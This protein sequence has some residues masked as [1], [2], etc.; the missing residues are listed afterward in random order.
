MDVELG[1]DR[2]DLALVV[3]PCPQG[4]RQAGARSRRLGRQRLQPP[5]G[6][7]AESG[8][9]RV[10]DQG[11]EVVVGQRERPPLHDPGVDQPARLAGAVG[12]LP[13]GQQ[14]DR[15]AEHR[16]RR[17]GRALQRRAQPRRLWV[18]EQRQPARVAAK[19]G[20]QRARGQPG[21]QP[22]TVA[23]P[24]EGRDLRRR[25]PVGVGGRG[26]N[27]GLVGLGVEQQGREPPPQ[28]LALARGGRLRLRVAVGRER[29]ELVDVGEHGLGQE[30][31]RAAVDAGLDRDRRDPA[32][33][34]PRAEA[35]GGEQRVE[36]ASLAVL[37]P[38]EP[39]IHRVAG[40]AVEVGVGDQVDEL[41]QRLLHPGQD[42]GA[43]PAAERAA[44]GGHALADRGDDLVAERG[45]VR[46]DQPAD[47]RGQPAPGLVDVDLLDFLCVDDKIL[48]RTRGQGSRTCCVERLPCRS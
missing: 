21:Q 6:E 13:R 41:R 22:A 1:G 17:P 48:G 40:A 46:A 43:E 2:R 32:P 7:L 14:V 5:R 36:R 31:Q 12:A 24:G 47:P 10:G 20:D 34:D 38:A 15:G 33:G 39:A 3:E 29:R 11:R 9:V 25:F 18:G 28:P 8:L 37:A 35:V 16:P 45:D 27:R 26:A 30:G 42:P 4:G 19:L 44:V 23:L